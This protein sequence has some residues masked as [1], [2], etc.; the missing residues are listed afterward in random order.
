MNRERFRYCAGV[1]CDNIMGE[2]EAG[3]EW[4]GGLCY[5]CHPDT[6][7][8]CGEDMSG[9]EVDAGFGRCFA[10]GPDD[11]YDPTYD[12]TRGCL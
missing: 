9:D 12:K 5:T 10:C 8:S 4:A 3:R 2:A 6:C 1:G 11:G 7:G